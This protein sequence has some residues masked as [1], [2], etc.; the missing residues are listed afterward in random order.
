[1]KK[2]LI[3]ERGGYEGPCLCNARTPPIYFNLYCPEHLGLLYL[4]W[5]N[6]VS[7]RYFR[8][9]FLE[10]GGIF[11]QPGLLLSETSA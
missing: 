9:L 3:D 4:G 8:G 10:E 7:L 2:V 11:E 5:P 6:Q 1:V